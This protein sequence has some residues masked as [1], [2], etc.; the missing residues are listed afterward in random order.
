MPYTM[1]SAMRWDT[2][3]K[4]RSTAILNLQVGDHLPEEVTSKL[5]SG[6]ETGVT[7]SL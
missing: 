3:Q 7:K 2:G 5:K 4:L 1:T 6:R